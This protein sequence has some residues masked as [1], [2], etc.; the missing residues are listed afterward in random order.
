MKEK[1][2]TYGDLYSKDDVIYELNGYKV[3]F[4][5]DDWLDFDTYEDSMLFLTYKYY[6]DNKSETESER[7]ERL[8]REKAIA[9]E[10][11]IDQI[12]GE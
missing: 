10:K 5:D 7:K 11:K 1:I 3:S 9:R 6:N 8:L 12:L 2:F 4:G